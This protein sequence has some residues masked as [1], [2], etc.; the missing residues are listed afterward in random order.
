MS[1][2][3]KIARCV[4][5][6]IGGAWQCKERDECQRFTAFRSHPEGESFRLIPVVSVLI[7]S[8]GEKCN[9]RIANETEVGE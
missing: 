9:Y 8:P 6:P 3:D 5:Q 2:P 1:L 4:G 7:R